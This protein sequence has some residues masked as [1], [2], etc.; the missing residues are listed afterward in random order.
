MWNHRKLNDGERTVMAV[1]S[2]EGKRLTY[3]SAPYHA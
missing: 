2:A 1:K 3:Q